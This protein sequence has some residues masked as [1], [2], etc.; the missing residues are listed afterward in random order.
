MAR[1]SWPLRLLSTIVQC[2]VAYAAQDQSSPSMLELRLL[3]THGSDTQAGDD[4]SVS[5]SFHRLNVLIT[6][7]GKTLHNRPC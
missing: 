5:S 4:H 6:G 1:A 7:L 3:S 2:R